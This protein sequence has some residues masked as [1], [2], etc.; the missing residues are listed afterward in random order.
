M[1]DHSPVTKSATSVNS[2]ALKRASVT[3]WPLRMWVTYASSAAR[4][5]PTSA[6]FP[7]CDYGERLFQAWEDGGR[8]EA[9][10]SRLLRQVADSPLLPLPPIDH[11][12]P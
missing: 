7:G 12:G 5:W 8:T 6:A 9:S 3:V 4:E 11:T 1:I 10:L 2:V